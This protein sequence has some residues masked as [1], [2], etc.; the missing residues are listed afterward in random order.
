M[1]FPA[2]WIAGSTAC[3][4]APHPET[5]RLEADQKRVRLLVKTGLGFKDI[6]QKVGRASVGRLVYFSRV[7]K[8]RNPLKGLS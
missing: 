3:T 4:T 8:R 5:D 2:L 7:S 1:S 6:I